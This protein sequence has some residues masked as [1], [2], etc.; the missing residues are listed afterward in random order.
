MMKVPVRW[1]VGGI[2]CFV[3]AITVLPL[4]TMLLWNALVPSLFKGPTL[5][6]LQALGLLILSHLLF[7]GGRGWRCGGGWR[8]HR[9]RMRFA[10]KLESMGPEE[11]ERLRHEW[12]GHWGCC[13][14]APEGPEPTSPKGA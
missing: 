6:Y 12:F 13:S 9:W 5:G 8:S 14:H 3:V 2:V 11:R 10:E 1:I 4:V 7:R